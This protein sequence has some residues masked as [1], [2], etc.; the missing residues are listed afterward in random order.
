[1]LTVHT[2]K[3]KKSTRRVGFAQEQNE[4]FKDQQSPRTPAESSASWYSSRELDIF[5]YQTNMLAANWL[6]TDQSA[7]S[8]GLIFR[9]FSSASSKQAVDSVI[10]S[11]ETRLTEYSVGLEIFAIQSPRSKCLRRR[12]LLEQIYSFQNSPVLTQQQRENAI[13]TV[14]SQE[15]RASHMYA[16][17]VAHVAAGLVEQK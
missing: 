6:R 5:G 17:Y 4:A 10:K 9:V 3:T 1:M 7:T 2:K 16:R 13:Y 8:L 14:A 15:S 11:T 12:Y